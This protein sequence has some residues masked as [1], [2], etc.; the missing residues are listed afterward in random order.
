MVVGLEPVCDDIPL[1]VRWHAKSRVVVDYSQ[2]VCVVYMSGG[3][4]NVS[5]H[6]AIC[7]TNSESQQGILHPTPTIH[8]VSMSN[9]H[10]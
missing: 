7:N 9:L 2:L 6:V 1:Y 4:V 5:V 10:A 8:R 3:N